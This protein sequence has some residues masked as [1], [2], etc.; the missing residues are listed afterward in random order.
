MVDMSCV[1]LSD[2]VTKR[3]VA[4][5][6]RN[7]ITVSERAEILE[8]LEYRLSAGGSLSNTLI[9]LSRLVEAAN[10]QHSLIGRGVEFAGLVG[11]DALGK[12]YRAQMGAAGV[13]V[14]PSGGEE[15]GRV[16]AGP[17]GRPGKDAAGE[18]QINTGTVV[19]LTDETADRT[20]FSY[21]GTQK[22]IVVS[23]AMERS[24]QDASVLVLEGYV[25]E[26]PGARQTVLSAIAAAK[27]R[28]VRVAMTAGDAG[29][30]VRH[31][32]A[33]WEAIQAGV[34]I[35]FTNAAEA[36]ELAKCRPIV[37]VPPISRTDIS[38]ASSQAEAAALCLGPHCPGLVCVTD[39]SRGSVVVGVGEMRRIPPVW[40]PEAPIDTTGAGDAWCAGFLFGLLYQGGDLTQ[41]GR[42]AAR[43]AS[44]VISHTGP[45]LTKDDAATIVRE[46]W[47]QRPA[48]S[49]VARERLFPTP[50][51]YFHP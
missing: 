50:Q 37:E 8:G 41:L 42:L 11:N 3:G 39:G 49:S 32:D 29:V 46:T 44:A 16:V 27:R 15:F 10:E 2:E 21:L 51:T 20:L 22:E 12:F 35:L 18:G 33:M 34:D 24:I 1:V 9:D 23:E 14:L 43:A 19:V 30:A 5:G 40:K 47:V 48:K 36:T 4:R 17:A 28:G 6:S 7:L 38:P 26:L 13:R 45:T 31:G 25:F